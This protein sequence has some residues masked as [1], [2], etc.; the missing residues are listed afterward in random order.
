G[1]FAC[2]DRGDVILLAHL[3]GRGT[4]DGNGMEL[5]L[6]AFLG[7]RTGCQDAG[8]RRT[9]SIGGG[10]H[11]THVTRV[12]ASAIATLEMI[13]PCKDGSSTTPQRPDID[14]LSCGMPLHPR[15]SPSRYI[16]PP[17]RLMICRVSLRHP[18]FHPA[19]KEYAHDRC[20]RDVSIPRSL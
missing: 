20:R 11:C 2:D 18:W 5:A 19:R 12:A 15:Q 16:P 10:G 8:S 7:L 4:T 14:K 1:E 6:F 3:R 13:P 17:R 9:Y